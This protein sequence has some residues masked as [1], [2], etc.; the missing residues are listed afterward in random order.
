[1]K[2]IF[3]RKG[4]DS[5]WGGWPSPIL[6]DLRMVSLPIPDKGGI[7]YA[8]LRL[9][10]WKSYAHLMTELGMTSI[11]YPG[12]GPVPLASARATDDG[13]ESVER[14]RYI[15]ER[16]PAEGVATPIGRRAE[17]RS[18]TWVSGAFVTRECHRDE[19][20]QLRLQAGKGCEIA[21]Q[22]V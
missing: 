12:L 3:S 2:I 22:D 21:G 15:A 10:G 9:D 17:H 13:V 16:W 8:D 4:F 18:L 11:K 19:A 14:S 1:V 20:Q 6:P 7:P 5:G